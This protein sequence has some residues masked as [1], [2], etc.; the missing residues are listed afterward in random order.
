MFR[1]YFKTAIRNLWKSKGYSALNI[2]GLS[3]GMAVALVIGLWVQHEMSYD[4]FHKNGKN[5]GLIM[6]RTNFNDVKGVQAGIML[7]LYQEL[8]TNYPEV[9]N[10]LAR[11]YLIFYKE[12]ET[13]F[14]I[15]HI[16]DERRNPA[17]LIYKPL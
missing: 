6:K 9:K 11:E 12:T 10:I 14:N 4:T 13:E 1:N 3:V 15:V 2:L 7:P 5:I 8:K 17:E 16:W